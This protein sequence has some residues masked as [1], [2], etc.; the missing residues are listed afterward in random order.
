MKVRPTANPPQHYDLPIQPI[1]YIMANELG[2][3][4]GNVIKYV[5]R[6]REK[7]G[8]EDLHKA[9]HYLEILIDKTYTKDTNDEV[10]LDGEVV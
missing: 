5:S 3:C 1:D 7:N 10:Y 2:W 8:L 6:W 9:K 4:E